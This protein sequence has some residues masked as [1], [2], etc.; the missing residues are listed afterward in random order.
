VRTLTAAVANGPI[1]GVA[2]FC[3]YGA[4][5]DTPKTFK[6]DTDI[7]ANKPASKSTILVMGKGDGGVNVE[8]LRLCKK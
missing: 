3:I 7:I 6:Y 1:P 2:T 4:Q 5:I 8:S